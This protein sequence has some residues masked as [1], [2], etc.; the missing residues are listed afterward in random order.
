MLDPVA[1]ALELD[2]LGGLEMLDAAVLLRIGGPA[3]LAVD[4]Q[5]RAGDPRPQLLDRLVAHVVR[6]VDAHIVVELPAV[7]AVLVLVDALL[8]QVAGLRG[9]EML[10]LLLHALEGVLDRRV[11]ARPPGRQLPLLVDPLGHA[12]AHRLVA[13]LGNHLGR[14][15]EAFDRHQLAHLVGMDAGVAQADVAAQRMR[16]DRHRRQVLLVDELRQVVDVGRHRVIAVRRPLAVAMP[17]EIGA[18]HVP[19]LAQSLRHPVP[20]PAVIAP[21]VNEEKRRRFRVAPVDIMQT[22]TL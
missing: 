7:G 4:Q 14:R 6:L 22:Q 1:G 11:F 21:A 9:G 17:A 3:F 20:V 5:G 12:F 18:D 10:V 15:P 13:A 19:V 8:G 2:D 16:H